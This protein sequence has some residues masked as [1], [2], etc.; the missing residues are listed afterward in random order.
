[1]F[2]GVASA[3]IVLGRMVPRVSRIFMFMRSMMQRRT[4]A[5]EPPPFPSGNDLESSAW[6]PPI[7]DLEET[8]EG[9]DLPDLKKNGRESVGE[10]AG[11][12]A[13]VST[14]Y[15]HIRKKTF[16]S[17]KSV[18]W[19]SQ[20]R[21]YDRESAISKANSV[22]QDAVDRTLEILEMAYVTD[23]NDYVFTCYN[24]TIASALIAL[25]GAPGSSEASPMAPSSNSCGSLA[26]CLFLLGRVIFDAMSYKTIGAGN[27]LL[28]YFLLRPYTPNSPHVMLLPSSCEYSEL[29]NFVLMGLKN[30]MK[31]VVK[32]LWFI[33]PILI[34]HGVVLLLASAHACSASRIIMCLSHFY[35]ITMLLFFQAATA[36]N[37]TFWGVASAQLLLARLIPR[38]SR[39]IS[40]VRS[41][42]QRKVSPELR[43]SSMPDI[44]S[45]SQLPAPDSLTIIAVRVSHARI[46]GKGIQMLQPLVDVA[47]RSKSHKSVAETVAH[48]VTNVVGKTL[49]FLEVAYVTDRNDYIFT[50]YKSTMV[51][52]E[53][54]FLI[55]WRTEN[56]N[57][58]LGQMLLKYGIF[59]LLEIFTLV[60]IIGIC[61]GDF[62]I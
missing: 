52:A 24:T 54:T 40:F 16:R 23:R 1:H 18:S 56:F 31:A 6:L 19:D 3:Q 13:T 2:W 9:G 50:C 25:L 10:S 49:G 61:S 34:F 42:Y 12:R 29:V 14:R 44:E 17:Q 41:H 51:A 7:D 11:P 62:T 33:V 38:V 57:E 30:G 48:T 59:L 8:S 32:S 43:K 22:V 27:L 21:F 37:V 46:Q 5:P 26:R 39:I 55:R 36:S 45:M 20:S 58:T 4:V 47:H 15:K 28:L 60:L 53:I 35:A